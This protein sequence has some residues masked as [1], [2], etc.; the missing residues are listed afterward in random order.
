MVATKDTAH[1]LGGRHAAVVWLD[2]DDIVLDAG[3]VPV[4]RGERPTEAAGDNLAYVIYTSGSTGRPKG[5][6][7][8]QRML[9]SNQVMIRSVYQ[10]LGDAPPII[11]ESP[12]P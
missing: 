9:C 12:M 1:V 3:A 8:T 11:C 10:F 4:D 2:G 6:I 7:N 5:V